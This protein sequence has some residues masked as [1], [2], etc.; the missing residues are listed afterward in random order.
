MRGGATATAYDRNWNK[1]R[2]LEVKAHDFIMPKGKAEVT[3][4]SSAG[5]AAIPWLDVQF[6]TEGEGMVVPE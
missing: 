2:E 6:M 5:N 3:I 4:A 1:M